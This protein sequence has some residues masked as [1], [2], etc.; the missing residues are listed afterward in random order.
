VALL[1]SNSKMSRPELIA[2]RSILMAPFTCRRLCLHDRS[3]ESDLSVAPG[4]SP[5]LS[6]SPC[7]MMSLPQRDRVLGQSA[8]S[9]T[10]LAISEHASIPPGFS[11]GSE[12]GVSTLFSSSGR[13][14]DS[15]SD[16]PTARNME[17]GSPAEISFE[18][19]EIVLP[20]SVAKINL[21]L[22]KVGE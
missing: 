10:I 5:H 12:R 18:A 16:H 22:A 9:A 20:R 7:A 11:H 19:R 4:S 21:E 8:L 13:L 3:I 14:Q 6:R 1:R 15:R 17:S 2:L